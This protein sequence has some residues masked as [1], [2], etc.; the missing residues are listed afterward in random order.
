MRRAPLAVLLAGLMV[1]SVAAGLPAD[2]T[3]EAEDEAEWFAGDWHVHTHASH[4]AC[5]PANATGFAE[6][7]EEGCGDGPHTL[8]ASGSTRMRQA[9][10]RGLDYLRITDHNNL[11]GPTDARENYDGPVTLVPGYEHSLPGGHAGISTLNLF[12]RGLFPTPDQEGL[13]DL[14]DEVREEP[15]GLFVVNH[16]YDGGPSVWTQEA[17]DVGKADAVEVWNIHWLW[18]DD[19]FGPVV[20]T[21]NNDQALAYWT[22]ALN[23]GHELPIVGASDNHWLATGAI[24]GPGQPTT[25]VKAD[26]NEPA[27][28]IEAVHEGRTYV[29]WDF[30]GP[31]VTFT[32]TG[33]SGEAIV[34]DELATG[35]Q[36]TFRAE[37]TAGAG[38]RIRFV[39][40]H[41]VEAESLPGVPFAEVTLTFE[42]DCWVRADL[43]HVDDAGGAAPDKFAYRAIT[44]PIYVR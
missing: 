35:E 34:G 4:D 28:L 15:G 13:N 19:V 7:P 38:E 18:R 44:S 1:T 39:S 12:E 31:R 30:V 25:W 8:S 29:T 27:E 40:C 33:P 14:A 41:G 2:P 43:V 5:N 22:R 32:A 6:D 9:E 24:Q 21:S 20:G 37:V 16:P 10:A 26:A 3:G 42:E 23:D 11:G 17:F 36:L